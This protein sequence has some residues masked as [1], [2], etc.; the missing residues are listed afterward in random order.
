MQAGA[1][2]LMEQKNRGRTVLC[3]GSY[4]F[5]TLLKLPLPGQFSLSLSSISS[6][7]CSFRPAAASRLS[8]P[9]LERDF[10]MRL[11]KFW[12]RRR[13]NGHARWILSKGKCT[14][15]IKKRP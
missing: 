5:H 11:A 1:Q 4:C 6:L 14:R 3:A 9:R 7:I 12:K 2:I 10:D 8:R 15:R 13:R